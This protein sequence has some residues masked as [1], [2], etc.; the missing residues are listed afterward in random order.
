MKNSTLKCL[1]LTLTIYSVFACDNNKAK[2]EEKNYKETLRLREER[3][4]IREYNLNLRIKEETIRKQ[5]ETLKKQKETLRKQKE[6]L[7][8]Q[9]IEKLNRE[10]QDEFVIVSVSKTYFHSSPN[11]STRMKAYLVRYDEATIIQTRNGFGYIDFYNYETRKTTS[12][13]INLADVEY[14]DDEPGC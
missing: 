9:E 6:E 13:W 7:K 14:Y 3:I 12:G 1:F 11:F 10:F 4:K 8:Q 5:E 2:L